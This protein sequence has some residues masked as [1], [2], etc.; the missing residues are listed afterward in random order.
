MFGPRKSPSFLGRELR[1]R[2]QE[3]TELALSRALRRAGFVWR[4]VAPIAWQAG[5]CCLGS[6]HGIYGTSAPP[7]TGL[8]REYA[9]MIGPALRSRPIHIMYRVIRFKYHLVLSRANAST[10]N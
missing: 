9:V 4:R 2:A 8:S 6:P 3:Q 1:L 5:L 10:S 7:S